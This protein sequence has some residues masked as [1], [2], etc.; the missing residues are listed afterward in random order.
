VI[1]VDAKGRLFAAWQQWEPYQWREYR[2]LFTRSED[3]GLTWLP[4]PVRLDTLRQSRLSVRP[5]QLLADGD[6]RIYVT[7]GGDAF[8]KQDFFLN[9]SL[10]AGKT[11]LPKEMWLTDPSTFMLR[12]ATTRDTGVPPSP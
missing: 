2:I 10:D 7:W 1:A 6:G 5:L 12:Q 8:A 9:R 4:T 3:F 11:W